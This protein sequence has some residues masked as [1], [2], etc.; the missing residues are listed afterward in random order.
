VLVAVF[1]GLPIL[2]ERVAGVNV[3]DAGLIINSLAA[4]GAVSAAVAAVW[5]ATTDRQERA[6]ERKATDS[7][8]ANLVLVDLAPLTSHITVTVKNYGDRPIL[9][10]TYEN[11]S[12]KAFPPARFT[13][14]QRDINVIVPNRDNSNGEMFEV[15]AADEPT[16]EFMQRRFP[17]AMPPGQTPVAVPVR[18]TD[19]NGNCWQTTFELQGREATRGDGSV[20][21]VGSMRRVS[22][23]RVDRPAATCRLP[24]S[25]RPCRGALGARRA[26]RRRDD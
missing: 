11:V 14:Q 13:P 10:V 17:P 5:V 6:D 3:N 23:T 8:Q 9:D 20:A 19:A 26:I 16:R 18:F 25:R 15:H 1:L 4:G 12:V 7:A 21:T 24:H 2:L 22:T